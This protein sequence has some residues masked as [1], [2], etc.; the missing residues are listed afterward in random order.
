MLAL[1]TEGLD[2][3]LIH[4]DF[5]TLPTPRERDASLPVVD[6]V[7]GNPPFIRYQE[8]SG[9]VRARSLRAALA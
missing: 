7:V 3:H 5:F 9:E 2:G 1:E 8:H 4:Q 6:A